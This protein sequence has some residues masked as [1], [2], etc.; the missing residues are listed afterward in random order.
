MT[1]INRRDFVKAGVLAGVSF[2]ALDVSAQQAPAVVTRSVR[3]V[4]ISSGNGNRFRNGGTST[5]VEE[6][7]R[8][9]TSGTDVF[10]TMRRNASM[11]ASFGAM[12]RRRLS[13]TR[14]EQRP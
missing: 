6:A 2:G 5:C 3:P 9:M 10:A 7:F 13:T 4:V 1:D 8:R 14:K 11:P 12:P